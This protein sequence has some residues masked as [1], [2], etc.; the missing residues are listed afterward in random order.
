MGKGPTKQ[1]MDAELG[2]QH[3]QVTSGQKYGDFVSEAS[4]AEQIKSEGVCENPVRSQKPGKAQTY[5][6]M[7]KMR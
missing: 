3:Q 5:N 7:Y 6:S 4:E 1:R 2:I